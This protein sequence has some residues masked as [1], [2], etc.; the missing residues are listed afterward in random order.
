MAVRKKLPSVHEK[1][2][3][4]TREL[5]GVLRTGAGELDASAF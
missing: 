4:V 5:P 1:S 3:D 2:E